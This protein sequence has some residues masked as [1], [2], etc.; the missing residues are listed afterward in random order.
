M[1]EVVFRRAVQDDL[2][3]IVAM[4]ADDD[5]GRSRETVSDPVDP[6]YVAAFG[7]ID[8]DPN[9]LLIVATGPD[10]RVI[11]TL[12]LT[13]LIHLALR[14]TRRA[15]IEA[16]RVAS[17]ARGGGIGEKMFLWAIAEARSRRCSMV[18]LTTDQRRP[19]AH[20]FYRKLGFIPSHTGFKLPL[21]Q[22]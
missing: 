5:L 13:F 7:A 20:A 14:G 6:A 9:Q 2:P 12:Q 1:A 17:Q 8:K 3:A 11:G 21:R 22:I 15:Q 10:G 16:V 18:Q 4:L 19:E